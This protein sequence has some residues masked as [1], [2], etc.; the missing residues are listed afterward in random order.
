MHWIFMQRFI[1]LPF[2]KS[3]NLGEYRKRKIRDDTGYK[4]HILKHYTHNRSIS[5]VHWLLPKDQKNLHN[6]LRKENEMIFGSKSVPRKTSSFNRRTSG[7]NHDF[8]APPGVGWQ[9]HTRTFD[10][11]L[12]LWTVQQL[13]QGETEDEGGPIQLLGGFQ[14]WQH[15][16]LCL[17]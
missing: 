15:V 1:W 6:L 17:H 16:I 9:C 2:W 7:H 14:G 10:T 11:T 5:L 8:D 4:F 13:L 12:V 3:K